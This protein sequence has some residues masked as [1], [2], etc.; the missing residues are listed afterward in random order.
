[1]LRLNVT[2][3]DYPQNGPP[4][5]FSIVKG[6]ETSP[7]RIDQLGVIKTAGLLRKG[8]HILHVQVRTELC[9]FVCCVAVLQGTFKA[10]FLELNFTDPCGFFTNRQRTRNLTD[11]VQQLLFQQN[12]VHFL[13]RNKKRA[14]GE[15]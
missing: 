2:D 14:L 4:F 5:S 10:V 12:G 11:R 8:Q 1:V 13:F 3:N 7:F 9:P 6:D 15:P